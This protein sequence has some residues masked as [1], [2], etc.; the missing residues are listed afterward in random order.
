VKASNVTN[1]NFSRSTQLHGLIIITE[2]PFK[3]ISR[4]ISTMAKG[5]EHEIHH[6]SPVGDTVYNAWSFASPPLY[7]FMVWCLIQR[8]NILLRFWARTDKPAQCLST[9]WMTEIRF[10][11]ANVFLSHRT[12]TDFV[13]NPLRGIETTGS[14]PVYSLHSSR[15]RKDLLQAPLY[16]KISIWKLPNVIVFLFSHNTSKCT[17]VYKM[18]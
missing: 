17:N 7:T 11:T 15:K 2:P 5:Q 14:Q 16:L 3:R 18:L 9:S 8:G 13:T 1:I 12:Q 4:A 10:P 6:S